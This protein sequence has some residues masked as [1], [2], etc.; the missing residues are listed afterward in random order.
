MSTT[1]EIIRGISQA[2]ANAYDG[3]TDENGE[4]LKIG[5]KRE[6]GHPF[7]D[8]RVMDG[9]TVKFLGPNMCIC[10]H[11]ELSVD[12]AKDDKFEQEIGRRYR[13]IVKFLK[14]E[15]KRVTGNTLSLT[16]KGD[17]NT[18]VQYMSRQRCWHNSQAIYKVGGVEAKELDAKDTDREQ[19]FKEFLGLDN[20][21]KRPSND[22]R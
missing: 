17:I 7:L 1:L 13:E 16:Q 14:K 11:A 5:L 21:N 3:A 12:E 10:Y 4:A 6:E 22:K 18:D 19:K 15:Y 9:F 2:A 8:K 20:K